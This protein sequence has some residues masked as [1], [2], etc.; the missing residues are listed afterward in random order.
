MQG[1]SVKLTQYLTMASHGLPLHRDDTCTYTATDEARTALTI[2]TDG[3][4]LVSFCG[5]LSAMVQIILLQAH[6]SGD[7]FS[8]GPLGFLPDPGPP[9]QLNK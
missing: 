8:P 2:D 4:G 9:Q 3:L 7:N 6:V 1:A 5:I